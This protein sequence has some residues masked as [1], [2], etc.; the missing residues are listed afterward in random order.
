MKKFV[1]ATT[2]LL[3]SA[4]CFAKVSSTVTLTS[5]YVW[6]GISQNIPA[7]SASTNPPGNSAGV[8]SIQG[9]IDYATEFGLSFGLFV[10]N[11]TPGF[12]GYEFDQYVAYNKAFGD[13]G[14]T[15][16]L[17]RYGYPANNVATSYEAIIAGSWKD[18]KLQL[19]YMPEYLGTKAASY[20]ANL[21]YAW[22][23]DEKVSIVPA[24]GY[25]TFS[26]E[27]VALLSNYLDTKVALQY[28]NEGWT[29]EIAYIDSD[30]KLVDAAGLKTD[31][32]RNE[33]FV[34]SITKTF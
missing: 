4:P 15:G 18:L 24:V 6:R 2:V 3:A 20:Y 19:A 31:V 7:V 26:D 12:G 14:I 28:A 21:S 22:K 5:E 8:P 25:T 34:F 27:K 13:F 32:E 10:S 16:T 9:S 30:V 33:K 11:V 1:A 17:Y 23:L 29:S